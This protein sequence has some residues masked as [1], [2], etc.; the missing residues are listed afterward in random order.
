MKEKFFRAIAAFFLLVLIFFGLKFRVAAA[1][2][3]EGR[4]NVARFAPDE[5]LV[6]FKSDRTAFRRIAVPAGRTVE[7][8]VVHYQRDPQVEYAEPNYYAYALGTVNDPYYQ[9]QWHLNNNEYG[10]IKTE[11]AWDI[12]TGSGIKVAVIDTGVAYENYCQGSWWSRTCY[13]KAPDFE[14]TCFVAGYD[15]VNGDSHANDDSSP[16]HGT[17]VAGIASAAIN[18]SGRNTSPA[19][20]WLPMTSMPLESPCSTASRGSISL[21]KAS[22][23]PSLA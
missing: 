9:Y 20:N 21:L 1:D 18:N 3:R 22:L 14:G 15:F 17:H 12:S 19:S 5:I 7:D 4:F 6:R 13:E 2:L 10:G 23:A 8:L 11:A 16:G